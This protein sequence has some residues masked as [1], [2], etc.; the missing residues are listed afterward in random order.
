MNKS[1]KMGRN[2]GEPARA[3]VKRVCYFCTEKQTPAYTDVI[4]LRKFLS[5]RGKIVPKLR[6][7]VCSKH[8]RAFTREV[9]HARHL[10]LLPF[11]LRV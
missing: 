10:A 8:Q 4:G 3:R 11:T 1:K 5:A 2:D 7:G 9:K 6:S